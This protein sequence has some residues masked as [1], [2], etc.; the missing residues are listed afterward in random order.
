MYHLIRSNI[1]LK[2]WHYFLIYT[3]ISFGGMAL[4]TYVGREPFV[5]IT[6]LIGIIYCSKYY[7]ISKSPLLDFT[8]L[9]TITLFITLLISDLTIG[10][11]L[12]II[13]TLLFTIAVIVCDKRMFLR[14]YLNVVSFI[15]I[16]SLFLY[17]TTRI[18][19]IELFTPLFPYLSKVGNNTLEGGVYS[20]GGFLY[21]WVTVHDLRN[22]GPFGEPGQYQGVLSVALYF[23]LFKPQYFKS[24]REQKLY[25][26]IYTITLLT[27][28]STNGYIALSILILGYLCSHK[29]Q[30]EIKKFT[31]NLILIAILIFLFTDIGKSFF[32]VAIYNKFYNNGEFSLTSNTTGARTK[33]IGDMILFIKNNPSAL[34][35]MGY[36]NLEQ[37]NFD[38]VSGLPKLLFAIGALPM[39]ILINGIIYF[40]YHY[41]QKKIESLIIFLL[42]LSMGF[43]QPHI[44]NPSIF[45]MVFYNTLE[46]KI[47]QKIN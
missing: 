13:G 24:I 38:T 25:I 43:G 26:I 11:I 33:G 30:K 20:Y 3:A 8:F 40:S 17:T 27:T 47:K 21:R 14:R 39:F 16:V 29:K 42:F 45:F 36:D 23:S 31:I 37:L 41:T 44:M 10:S 22:C 9:F 46:K 6:F 34:L 19:G 35:G 15:A 5:L 1:Y 28:L 12:S 2:Y 4:P 32:D 18:F 7:T